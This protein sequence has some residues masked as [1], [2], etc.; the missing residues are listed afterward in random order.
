MITT[1]T[2]VRHGETAANQGN[3]I[4]GQTDVP[5][6]EAGENQAKLLGRRWKNKKFDAVYSSDLSRARRTAEL[7]LPSQP[8]T[9]SPLL[10]EM[11]LGHWC[12]RTT[13]EIAERFPDEWKAFRS[14]SSECKIAGG[15]TRRELFARAE[16]FF[17][18]AAAKHRGKNVLVVTHGGLLR[19]FFL[20][21]MGGEK[22]KFDL[23]PSTGNTGI[24]VA[25]YDDE[26]H[27]WRLLTWNDTAHLESLLDGDDAY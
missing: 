21:V 12:G 9:P 7:A 10:R 14:G 3:I 2:V 27:K 4:Q 23:L 1:F 26:T 11:D 17:T 22:V 5:L 15:E 18:E 19:A 25:K 20:L 8:A 24:S 16:K 6:S 13:A